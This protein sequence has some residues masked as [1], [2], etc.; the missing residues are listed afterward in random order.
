[1]SANGI[2]MHSTYNR[3]QLCIWGHKT[4]TISVCS[5]YLDVTHSSYSNIQETALPCGNHLLLSCTRLHFEQ[6]HIWGIY[7][8]MKGNKSHYISCYVILRMEFLP[9]MNS[10]CYFL[11][12]KVW[13]DRELLA[14]SSTLTGNLHRQERKVV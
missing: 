3:L 11:R 12:C 9:K 1:M 13:N 10:L 7:L 5:I 4:K 6:T 8:D 2:N 14:N